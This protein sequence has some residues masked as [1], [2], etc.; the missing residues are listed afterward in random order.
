MHEV[1]HRL[2]AL[3]EHLHRL[4]DATE[5]T[6]DDV[7]TGMEAAWEDLMAAVYSASSKMKLP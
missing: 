2:A 1:V 7:K 3:R 6:W 4:R 5:D